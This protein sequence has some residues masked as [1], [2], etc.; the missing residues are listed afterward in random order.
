MIFLP[1]WSFAL[2]CVL[3]FGNYNDVA[4]DGSDS[5]VYITDPDHADGCCNGGNPISRLYARAANGR[6]GGEPGIVL[7]LA[8]VVILNQKEK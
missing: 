6:S 4:V 3:F 1:P 7:I 8:A 2:F 5:S